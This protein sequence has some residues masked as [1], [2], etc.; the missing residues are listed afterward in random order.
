MQDD[1]KGRQEQF[2]QLRDL[3]HDMRRN[4]KFYYFQ[5]EALRLGKTVE[6]AESR[7]TKQLMH[8]RVHSGVVAPYKGRQSVRRGGRD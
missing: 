5:Q 1:L 2:A 4:P 7:P 8:E 6:G 3:M